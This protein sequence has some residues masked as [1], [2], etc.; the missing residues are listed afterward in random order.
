MSKRFGKFDCRLR[1]YLRYGRIG[2]YFYFKQ[3]FDAAARFGFA[4]D[5]EP[6]RDAQIFDGKRLRNKIGRAVLRRKIYDLIVA[7]RSQTAEN[8]NEQE[9]TF[10]KTNLQKSVRGF[11]KFFKKELNKLNGILLCCSDSKALEKRTKV[12]NALAEALKRSVK[13]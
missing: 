9:L 2:N 8:L 3:R 5:E 11:Y 12:Q 6:I 7:Y 10:G 1:R 13:K 4:T